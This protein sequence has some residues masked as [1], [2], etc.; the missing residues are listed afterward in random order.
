MSPLPPAQDKKSDEGLLIDRKSLVDRLKENK[1][2]K[3]EAAK[4]QAK[5]QDGRL[6]LT[7]SALLPS[8]A[9]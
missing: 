9:S 8:G 2:K 5:L 7:T 3:D 1:R 4:A 6:V